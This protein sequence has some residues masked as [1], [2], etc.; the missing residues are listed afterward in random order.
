MVYPAIGIFILCCFVAGI[1]RLSGGWRKHS[2]KRKLLIA[3]EIGLAVIFVELFMIPFFAPVK[4]DLRFPVSAFTYGFRDRIRSEADIPAIRDWL[5]TLDKEDFPELGDRLPRDKWP[6][7]LKALKPPRS[8]YLEADSNG[9]PQLRIIWGGGF[10]H[11][12]VTIGLEDMEIPPS[13]L[14]DGYESWLL[15]EPGV[16]VWDF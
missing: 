10:F 6:E 15:V 3:A 13:K 7:S 8:V 14:T 11:W 5:R 9:R 12:G 16:Y 4:S 2:E 1:R